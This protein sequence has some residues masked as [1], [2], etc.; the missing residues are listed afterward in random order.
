MTSDRIR[1]GAD[2]YMLSDFHR[3]LSY[4]LENEKMT[5]RLTGQDPAFPGGS[6]PEHPHAPNG[7]SKLRGS[8]VRR[9]SRLRPPHHVCLR[10]RGG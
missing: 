3:D 6:F 10:H 4:N 7:M 5:D 2:P 9:P 1:S 8:Q